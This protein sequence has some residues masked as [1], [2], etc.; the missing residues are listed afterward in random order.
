MSAVAPHWSPPS[1]SC[2]PAVCAQHSGHVRAGHSAARKDYL[3][4]C[5]PDPPRCPIL[6]LTF[7]ASL[8]SGPLRV[9]A[10]TAWNTRGPGVQVGPSSTSSGL[11]IT[12]FCEVFL[13]HF[14]AH[15]PHRPLRALLCFISL[16]SDPCGLTATCSLIPFIRFLSLP[17]GEG[18]V[19]SLGLPAPVL[20]AVLRG[21]NRHPS[22]GLR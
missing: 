4:P 16:H 12:L 14:A 17:E 15:P 19:V 21:G 11:G 10:R 18:G 8:T 3:A 6:P 20:T 13:L 2:H 7:Q 22:G 5:L 1:H 9:A